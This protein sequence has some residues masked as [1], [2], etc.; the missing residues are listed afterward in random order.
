MI[1]TVVIGLM[2]ALFV[3]RGYRTTG[4]WKVVGTLPNGYSSWQTFRQHM[5]TELMSHFRYAVVAMIACLVAA[6]PT[7]A[8]EI[9][10][11]PGWIHLRLHGLS[12]GD[13]DTIF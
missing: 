9:F 5:G 1:V 4:F 8:S 10:Y 13:T 2:L 12:T 11:H 7:L 3:F 6:Q